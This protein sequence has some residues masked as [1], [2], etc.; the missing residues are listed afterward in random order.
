MC[1]KN[2]KSLVLQSFFHRTSTH[3]ELYKNS[4]ASP[5]S[6]Y[7][8][9]IIFIAHVYIYV[10]AAACTYSNTKSGLMYFDAPPDV[11]VLFCIAHVYMYVD[12]A[13]CT[14]SKTKSA[15]MYFDAPPDRLTKHISPPVRASPIICKK[16]NKMKSSLLTVY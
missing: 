8:F 10:D 6:E 11:L 13:A 9:C 4:I 7:P 14:Y 16:T 12:A 1:A 15:L 3:F 5:K 2:Y